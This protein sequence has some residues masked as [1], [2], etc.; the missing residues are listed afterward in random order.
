[1]SPG[2][3]PATAPLTTSRCPEASG[4]GSSLVSMPGLIP[5]SGADWETALLLPVPAAEPA[6]GQH[7]GPA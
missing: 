4:P 2:L 7:P 1:M 3:S 6:V 5:G